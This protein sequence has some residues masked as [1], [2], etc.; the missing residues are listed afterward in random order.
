MS[1]DRLTI[2]S[3][4]LPVRLTPD[5]RGEWRAHRSDGGL[6]GALEPV[7]RQRG[8]T[9]VGWSGT[10]GRLPHEAN[11]ELARHTLGAGFQLEPVPLSALEH[12]TFY[13]GACN[14]T[15]WPLLHGLPDRIRTMGAYKRAYGSVNLRFAKVVAKVARGGTVWVH[16]YHL[17]Q[18]G[19]E[20]RRRLPHARLGF[21]FHT[22]FP[23]PEVMHRLPWGAS[24][25][26]SLLCFD[27]IGFQTEDDR[28]NFQ[29]WV[30]ALLWLRSERSAEAQA[31]VAR[32]TAV[33]PISVDWEEFHDGA[34]APGVLARAQEIRT[35]HAGR[36]ILLG[37]DRLDYTKGIP[38]R[39]TAYERMLEMHPELMERVVFVQLAVPSRTGI[40]EYEITRARVEAIVARVNARFGSN[41]W[42]PVR[43]LYGTWSREELLAWYVG[44]DVA[45]VTPLR[46]GMNLVAKEFAAANREQGVLVLSR[47]AGAARE[48]GEGALLAE[49]SDVGAL[50]STLHD[51]L[52]LPGGERRQR[53]HRLQEHV[54]RNDV[55]RWA[56][57][58]L[59]ALRGDGK[60]ESRRR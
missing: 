12:D 47:G 52:H 3:N 36:R 37:V 14:Q 20:L 18:M 48:L 28:L 7:L 13:E 17:L 11:A 22:P 9:W 34:S 53:L 33:F 50:A 21:F 54:R 49:P 24:L 55:H 38:E 60:P 27:V 5:E 2:V 57:S 58:F 41:G 1:N 56:S 44:A 43:Y 25:L 40:A 8:G 29:A 45:V 10:S 16:D 4:R 46:D 6:V 39:L 42:T 30:G 26:P 19:E 31:D 51:A 23:R 35:E 15:L 32:R 59:D